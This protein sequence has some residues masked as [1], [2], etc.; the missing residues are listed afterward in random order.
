MNTIERPR[1]DFANIE[2]ATFIALELGGMATLSGFLNY[3]MALV[4]PDGE[5][6]LYS[7]FHRLGHTADAQGELQYLGKIS[8]GVFEEAHPDTL[9]WGDRMVLLDVAGNRSVHPRIRGAMNRFTGYDRI[10]PLFK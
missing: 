9:G 8:R 2:L 6:T 7:R 4:L 1:V 5:T 10:F 3:E